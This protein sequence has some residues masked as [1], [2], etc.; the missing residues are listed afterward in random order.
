M[1]DRINLFFNLYENDEELSEEEVRV[2][3]IASKL[4]EHTAMI[5][6]GFIIAGAIWWIG[7]N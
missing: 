5:Y 1:K 6:I 2:N 7:G 4:M 3:N